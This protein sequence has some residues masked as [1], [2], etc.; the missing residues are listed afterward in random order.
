MSK[1]KYLLLLSRQ[2]KVRLIRWYRSYDQ[3]EKALILREI[4]TTV[5][6]R[7]PRMC[8]ILEYQDHKIVYKRYAS[9]FFICGISP[10]DNELLT[11]EIIHRFVESMD[12]YFGNVCELD[13]IF[14]FSR[15]YNILDELIMCD[16][17]FVESSKTSILTS[18][19]IMD[20]VES[21]DS[22]E[23]VLS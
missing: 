5:L 12:R 15:A 9:L 13:I 4:T 14:N 21:N 17:A 10:E 2:G 20:S 22:L 11:L 8:N 16:G 1:I 18:M 19:A 23:K 7:K 3:R 6:S